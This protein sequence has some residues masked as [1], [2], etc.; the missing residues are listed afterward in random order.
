MGVN[1][2][3]FVGARAPTML[4]WAP[5]TVFGHPQRLSGHPQLFYRLGTHNSFD[6]CKMRSSMML[7]CKNQCILDAIATN[8]AKIAWVREGRWKISVLRWMGLILFTSEPSC[9][10]L[11]GGKRDWWTLPTLSQTFLGILPICQYS[12]VPVPLLPFSVMLG[13]PMAM[14]MSLLVY[15]SSVTKR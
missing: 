15:I 4:K 12:S 2:Y 11:S 14:P 8:H 1:L 9:R 7:G 6:N 3:T 5:T 13:L 10:L